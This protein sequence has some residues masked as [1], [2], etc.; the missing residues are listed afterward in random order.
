MAGYEL[1]SLRVITHECEV[2]LEDSGIWKV[3]TLA[4]TFVKNQI[5]SF[6]F[7][8]FRFIV[9]KNLFSVCLHEKM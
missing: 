2:V 9:L 6:D 5:K 4:M 8:L 7:D 3:L 1:V